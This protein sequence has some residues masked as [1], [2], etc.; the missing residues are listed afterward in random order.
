MVPEVGR[1]LAE[2]LGGIWR[3]EPHESCIPAETVAALIP[4]LQRSGVGALSFWRLRHQPL[5]RADQVL[6]PLRQTYI[7][8]AAHAAQ[9][10]IEIA[11]V[12]RLLRSKYVEPILLKGWAIARVYPEVGLRPSGDIDLC[13]SPAERH[14]ALTTVRTL[15][16]SWFPVDLD[17]GSI[18]RFTESGFDELYA[19]SEVVDLN[20][21]RIR[22]LGPEDHLRILC[23][24]L[25]THGA[26]RPLWLCDIAAAL[27]SRPS[28]FNWCLCLGENKRHAD[29]VLCAI[30]LANRPLGADID[31][32][33]ARDRATSL[34][35]WLVAAVLEE[36]SRPRVP[37]L[38]RFVD[39]LRRKC[40]CS[41]ILRAIGER[42]PN[43]IQATID[44]DGEFD[45]GMRLPFQVRDC[46]LR[47]LRLWRSWIEVAA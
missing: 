27:E 20:G 26:W 41:D 22:I 25:F 11:Q 24:H 32:T 18:S 47:A 4:L 37:N 3:N 21:T 16:Q 15:G 5:E 29:W 38:T 2:M 13:I 44:A 45:N 8:Y 1:V 17:H 46:A 7:H 43:P 39:Q 12:F 10:E 30:A 19:H 28:N 33:P 35:N 23:L 34:P 40:R 42:W 9:H 6:E 31:D 14:Q 36:W